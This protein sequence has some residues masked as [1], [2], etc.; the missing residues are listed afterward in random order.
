MQLSVGERL[1]GSGP[2]QQP[3]GYVVTGVVSETPWSGLYTAK[4]VFYN[5]D[6]TAKRIRETDDKE[7]LDVFLRTIRYPVLDEAD[8]VSQR[9]ALAR[10]EVRAILG[11]R[12][13]N[14]WPEPIDLIELE[15][16]R[17]LF[18]FGAD[19]HAGPDS[20]P[21][22]VF[23]RPHGV[24]LS[25]WLKQL[26]PLTSI[27]SVLAELLEFIR[28]AHDEGL[29]L[30]GLAPDAVVVDGL[31]R[32]HYVGTDMALDAQSPLLAEAN[33]SDPWARFFPPQRFPRGFAAPEC[34]RP[35]GR[36]D[37]RSD[38]YAWGCLVYALFTGDSPTQM[39]QAQGRP[40]LLFRDEH[41][42]RLEAVLT[43][44]PAALYGPW[45]EQLGLP[46]A[47]PG[48]PSH[49]LGVLRLLL[50]PN[51]NHR[52]SSVAELRRWLVHLPPPTVASMVALQLDPG[53]AR[54]LLDCSTID[55]SLSL[56]IRRGRGR[57]PAEPDAG[58]AIYDGRPRSV[59]V[60]DDLPLT[61]DPLP[62]YYT[63]WTVRDTDGPAVY[64]SA[65]AEM[66]WQ[67]DAAN[68]RRWAE[69]YAAL[70]Q[71]GDGYP[72]RIAMV[73][74]ALDP[75]EAAYNLLASAMASVRGWGLRRI[76]IAL[77]AGYRYSLV[78]GAL[79]Q[80]LSDSVA[81]MRL[82]AARAVW[83]HADNRDDELL[84]R[85]LEALEAPPEGGAAP[86]DA[87]LR[88]LDLSD[89]RTL[90]LMQ[91]LEQRR[92]TACP[93]C[94][95]PIAKGERVAHLRERHGYID[96]DG[97]AVPYAV[98]LA[99]LWERVLQRQESAAHDRLLELYL[100]VTPTGAAEPPGLA[101][102]V[103]DLQ[104]HVLGQTGRGGGDGVRRGP[105]DPAPLPVALSFAAFESYLGMLRQCEPFMPIVRLMLLLGDDRLRELARDAILPVLAARLRG[106]TA[107]DDIW[108]A[109]EEACLGAD[110]IE[111]R[112]RLCQR[113]AALGVDAAAVAVC[114]SRLQDERP[115]RCSECAASVR[116]KDIETHLRRVHQI[117]E[118]RGVRR[119]FEATR[120]LLLRAVCATPP[121]MKAWHQL[122][123]VVE[124]RYPEAADRHLVGWLY[125]YLRT[126][127][128]EVRPRAVI[129]LAEALAAGG[130]DALLPTLVG[131]SKHSSWEQIGRRLA[132]E[133][134]ARL[135]A[136][137][138]D[139]VI[140][141]VKPLLADKDLPRKT[142]Q[143]SV[144]ALL[145]TTG[146][147]GPA[148]KELLR[149]YVVGAG[150]LRAIEK[151]HLL[152]QRFGQAPAIDEL[153]RELEDE[154]RM[155]CPRCPTQL[156]KKDMVRHLWDRH[157]LV[158]DGERVREPWRVLEDWAVDYGL[159]KDPELLK[160]C[161]DLARQVDPEGG[162]TRL[163]RLM[164][165]RGMQDR[166][167][168]GALVAQAR[169][170]QTSLCP[171]CYHFV[172]CD[173]PAPLEPLTLEHG[174][175]EGF[176]YRLEVS[177][178]GIVPSLRIESPDDVLFD[179][180]EP[181]RWLTRLGGVLFLVVPAI[182]I[183]F[184]CIQGAFQLYA[185]LALMF[186]WGAG[187]IFAGLL[188]ALWPTPPPNAVRL[189]Q[190][191]WE[192]LVPRMLIEP[193]QRPEWSFLAGLAQ[194][195][196]ESGRRRPR[197]NILTECCEM[198]AA[199]GKSDPLAA[200]C[201]AELSRLYVAVLRDNR[202]DA[203]GFLADQLAEC[204]RGATSA[205]LLGLVLS[206]L[207]EARKD[208]S[209][210][211]L[212]RLQVLVAARAFEQGLST[213]DVIDLARVFPLARD[214]LGLED[215][216]RWSQLEL[217]W[218]MQ[219]SRAWQTAGSAASIFELAEAALGA[220]ALLE[221][222]PNMLLSVRQQDLHVTSR[223]VWVLGQYLAAR[224]DDREIMWEW[225]ADDRA[226]VIEVGSHRLRSAT[227][228]RDLVIALKAWLRFYF[229]DFLPRLPSA[230]RPTSDA[231]QKMW[232]GLRTSCP[233][234]G[235]AL[236]PC[237]GDVGIALR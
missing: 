196:G 228:P 216:W 200:R 224:P 88:Q 22:V 9:R 171:H 7:W 173:A 64:S 68:L 61:T 43:E 139:H 189:L 204:F 236:V 62:L 114:V 180:R 44:V 153:C 47:M 76:E 56:R 102:Y 169:A 187:L 29:L 19:E 38:L 73:L 25:E 117:F 28:Q 3:G 4:K 107:A 208:W 34:F 125:Q 30:L 147:A 123:G 101:R 134:S 231:A 158:L 82:A 132:L 215:R 100:R 92:P 166:E 15:N 168:V 95:E 149:A 133:L 137:V 146:R 209:R 91:T 141:A 145:R 135:A 54:L 86:V 5:F 193:L 51:S 2:E 49:L 14:L 207:H 223:G 32:V 71:D 121:D 60:D 89:E 67:P 110:M 218:S 159:E 222:Y 17:D 226:Y 79:W 131:P 37:R 202:Q 225:S 96:H 58:E 198:L 69:E 203:I 50:S 192:Q 45:T 23:A 108:H 214:I 93:L 233:D 136:P 211:S 188:Y 74:G 81:A 27:L 75:V 24:F 194:L 185:V 186:A 178:G 163:H 98:A 126:C 175:L 235:R 105:A 53:A 109:L 39:A 229:I 41:F 55:P 230:R 237:M 162:L 6:F 66:L 151:L 119:S 140:D 21:I 99:Q 26:L 13:S 234:C 199:S 154:V 97:D 63:A 129:G 152:E 11:N 57:A 160:R 8:Y 36:P 148:A 167:I 112:L 52:P 40:W 165:R 33:G 170:R 206:E 72:A 1:E 10:A 210:G 16:P 164:L 150:K 35:G 85:L 94:S 232:H 130:A 12:H 221:E 87:F 90:L 46:A 104:K 70:G 184:V 172:P 220:E 120:E 20:E 156:R 201:L 84:V 83:A 190:A 181:G 48:W 213:D 65:V 113:L 191:A 157:R 161:R 143:R 138:P 179:G 195:S 217:L 77:R 122:R 205:R 111:E 31:E 197:L 219:R 78:E 212:R 227:K 42:A 155:S 106:N 128:P 177:K 174:V 176:G 80:Y 59:V 144:L 182:A 18:T 183:L 116:S 142:R 118:F 127:Q 103:A 124:D 115:V